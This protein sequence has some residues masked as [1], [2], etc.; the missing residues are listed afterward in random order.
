[1]HVTRLYCGKL[2]SVRSVGSGVGFVLLLFYGGFFSGFFGLGR[3]LTS[4]WGKPR[5]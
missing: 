3:V 2:L 4:A 1:M 5:T